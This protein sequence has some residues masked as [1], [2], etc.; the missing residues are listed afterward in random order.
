MKF[1]NVVTNSICPNSEDWNTLAYIGTRK[2]PMNL[3]INGRIPYMDM[4]LK[5][6]FTIFQYRTIKNLHIRLMAPF[7]PEQY[8]SDRPPKVPPVRAERVLQVGF[9]VAAFRLLYFLDGTGCPFVVVERRQQ[10]GLC[11]CAQSLH[12]R[13]IKREIVLRQRPYPH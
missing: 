1:T 11:L 10:A 4:F 5:N 8:V 7:S 9:S 13:G 3:P 6:W 2:N 12:L